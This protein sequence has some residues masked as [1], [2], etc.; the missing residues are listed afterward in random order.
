MRS[1]LVSTVAELNHKV[2]Y[3]FLKVLY[4][5]GFVPGII[6]SLGFFMNYGQVFHWLDLPATPQ[7]AFNDPD[8]YTL[9]KDKQIDVLAQI[10]S[11]FK[12][13]QYAEQVQIMDEVNQKYSKPVT[14][15]RETLSPE[16][17]KVLAKHGYPKKYI[18]EAYSSWDAIPKGLAYALISAAAYLFFMWA[19]RHTFYY[20]S[21]GKFFPNE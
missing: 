1:R 11:E 7:E 18:Y 3:R 14:Q 19:I 8:F 5:I 20:V 4:L 13:L 16:A 10:D 15:R 6:I 9:T 21:I 12:S 17:K 2:W